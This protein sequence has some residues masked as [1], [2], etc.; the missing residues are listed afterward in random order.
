M[1]TYLQLVHQVRQALRLGYLQQGDNLPT[2]RDAVESLA[3]NPNT[4]LKAY[5]ELEHRGPRGR[6]AGPGDL[7]RRHPAPG[8]PGPAGRAAQD[9]DDLA[10]VRRAGLDETGI[11]AVFSSSLRDLSDAAVPP[12]GRSAR[13]AARPGGAAPVT[14]ATAA[15][16]MARPATTAPRWWHEHPGDLRARQAL[17]PGRG[18]R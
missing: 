6:P 7:H 9:P 17:P 5:R 8:R 1:P 14:R 3:I 11:A 4:V 13:G 10:A 18:S 2:V 16:A 12:P 15:A